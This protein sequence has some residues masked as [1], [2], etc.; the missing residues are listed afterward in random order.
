VVI[1]AL[2]V[3]ANVTGQTVKKSCL[4]ATPSH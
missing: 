1:A 3:L 2:A 4:R